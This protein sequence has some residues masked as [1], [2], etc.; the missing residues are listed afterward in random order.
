MEVR[1]DPARV[2]KPRNNDGWLSSL[3]FAFLRRVFPRPGDYGHVQYYDT[4]PTDDEDQNK[5]CFGYRS[6]LRQLVLPS[7][8]LR[9]PVEFNYY[10]GRKRGQADRHELRFG[11]HSDFPSRVG[12]GEVVHLIGY[13]VAG[14]P[15]IGFAS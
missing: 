5:G 6:R 13:Q 1:L 4:R 11:Q 7:V 14:W 8:D 9:W 2:G 15:L 12:G 10:K 3:H